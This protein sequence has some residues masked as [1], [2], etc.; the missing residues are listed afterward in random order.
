MQRVSLRA[1]PLLPFAPQI[2]LAISA[3]GSAALSA[4]SSDD[5][6]ATAART[7]TITAVSGGA[8]QVIVGTPAPA[9]LV[10]KV[11]DQ[12]GVPISGYSV[13]FT[14]STGVTLDTTNVVTDSTGTAQVS[15]NVG[16]VAGTDSVTATVNG[17]VGTTLFVITAL[18][19][20]PKEVAVVAGNG[21]ATTAGS[22]LPAPLVVEVT[23]VYGNPV[24]NVPVDWAGGGSLAAAQTVT[25]S[26]GMAQDTVTLPA[27][28]GTDTI[29]AAVDGNA[30]AAPVKF[31][32][33]AN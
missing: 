16:T 29:T 4:C 5:T 17:G 30:S 21:Q 26:T 10:V 13:A 27:S 6:T 7:P 8:Q 20:A 9:P 23:D 3:L 11:V 28:T 15:L 25:N 31:T 32:E 14:S 24:P 19:G 22:P 2:L 1:A 33:N 18:P 12:S